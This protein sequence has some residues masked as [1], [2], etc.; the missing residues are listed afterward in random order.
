MW[1]V[2]QLSIED[3]M[4]WTG[5]INLKKSNGMVTASEFEIVCRS[6]LVNL[7]YK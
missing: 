6:S 7:E 3:I 1:I 5:T 2:D 4:K